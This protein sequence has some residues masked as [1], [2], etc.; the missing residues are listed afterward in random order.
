M[1]KAQFILLVVLFAWVPLAQCQDDSD[2]TY[3]T[4]EQLD[5]LLAPVALYPDP[6]LAQVLL[7]ATFPDQID[8]ANRVV[9]DS[10]DA[11]YID[12]QPWDVSVK[13]VA[14]Y[15][16]V[17]E[18]MADKLDWTTALGQ[19]YVNQSTDVMASVQRL[20]EQAREAGNLV[21]T[22]EQEVVDSDGAIKIWPAEPQYIYVPVYDPAI[23]YFRRP[24]F[25]TG[26]VI[27]FGRAFSI[28]VWLNHDFDWRDH[29][30]FYN[31]WDSAGGWRG[32][33]RPYI[34]ITNVY[35]NNR[36]R[37]VAIDR[38]VVR[39]SVN[40]SQLDR[41]HG[42]HRDTNYDNVRRKAAGNTGWRPANNNRPAVDNKIIQRNIDVRDSRIDAFRGRREGQ[43]QASRP[44][45]NRPPAYQPQPRPE[46]N[47]PPAYQPQPRPEANRPP[48]PQPQSRPPNQAQPQGQRGDNSA[49]GGGNRGEFDARSA[50]QRGQASRA[51]EARPQP[52]RPPAREQKAAPQQRSQEQRAPQQRSQD[53][54]GK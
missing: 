17:L 8:E 45:A 25:F 3:F 31:G 37:N 33:S 19:A 35:V 41:Y 2:D 21:T 14:H 43:P 26:A 5:N 13:A 52:S 51:Q 9:R 27:S 11:D 6:L 24:G 4:P 47:R 20:R 10:T 42:V 53:R 48:A 1:R 28:G 49:F 50:S 44:E 12:S 38:N 22:P 7:A 18:M 29:R 46:A 15:P 23:V 30:V 16:T 32:R 34:H 54:R 39:R 36:Y 40:Y